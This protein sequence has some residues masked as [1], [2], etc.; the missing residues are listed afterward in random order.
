MHQHR[1]GRLRRSEKGYF[2]YEDYYLLE[3]EVCMDC[4][5]DRPSHDHYHCLCCHKNITQPKRLSD[6][7][8]K[9]KKHYAKDGAKELKAGKECKHNLSSP[10]RKYQPIK[11]KD[12]TEDDKT[13]VREG[14]YHLLSILMFLCND[15]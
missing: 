11:F 1:L 15:N 14:F 7:N 4:S 3:W 5:N 9:L 10:P 6:T 12:L 2:H 13:V 8:W